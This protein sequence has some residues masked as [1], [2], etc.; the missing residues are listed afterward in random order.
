VSEPATPVPAP[1]RGLPF[2]AQVA[3]GFFGPGIVAVGLA[4]GAVGLAHGTTNFFARAGLAAL[5]CAAWAVLVLVLVR[6]SG[7]SGWRGV[8]VGLILLLVVGLCWVAGCFGL[9]RLL[10]HG[11]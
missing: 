6:A 8:R 10:L 7:K 11:H 3:V 2:G 9:A 5:C 4:L 1:R